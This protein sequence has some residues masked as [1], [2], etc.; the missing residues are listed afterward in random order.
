MALRERARGVDHARDLVVEAGEACLQT[1]DLA[2]F[3]QWAATRTYK[4]YEAMILLEALPKDMGGSPERAR[5][6]FE[7][8]VRFIGA[9]SDVACPRFQTLREQV[10]FHRPH[11]ELPAASTSS[12]V[13]QR[14]APFEHF[15]E[16]RAG[17]IP[18]SGGFVVH[19][20]P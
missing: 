4:N 6:H 11:L 3:G 8:A 20:A 18:A 10:A 7:R 13:R 14:A 1:H 15:I 17:I 16:R 12:H 5:Q 9:D 2:Q 19:H